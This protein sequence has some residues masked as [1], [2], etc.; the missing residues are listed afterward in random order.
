[1]LPGETEQI[2]IRSTI[3]STLSV[4]KKIRQSQVM[5]TGVRISSASPGC[6][7]GTA[8]KASGNTFDSCKD[9]NQ[10]LHH[11]C[12]DQVSRCGCKSRM[13]MFITIDSKVNTNTCWELRKCNFSITDDAQPVHPHERYFWKCIMAPPLPEASRDPPP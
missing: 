12:S 5:V 3:L 2:R 9:S 8:Y 4:G 13:W 10:L 6:V 7:F 11:F 1:M